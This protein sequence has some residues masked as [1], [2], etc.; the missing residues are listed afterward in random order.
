[1]ISCKLIINIHLSSAC[2]TFELNDLLQSS[3]I[4]LKGCLEIYLIEDNFFFL[5]TKE[6]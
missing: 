2:G 6:F 4:K 1:M 3:V 5:K